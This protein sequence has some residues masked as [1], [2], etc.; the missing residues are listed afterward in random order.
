MH[1][2]PAAEWI[3]RICQRQQDLIGARGTACL[4]V[5]LFVFSTGF[6]HSYH[7]C[8]GLPSI[9]LLVLLY[10]YTS[11]TQL[12]FMPL[13]VR[14]PVTWVGGGGQNKELAMAV[15]KYVTRSQILGSKMVV[16]YTTIC[17]LIVRFYVASNIVQISSWVLHSLYVKWTEK[18]VADEMCSMPSIPAGVLSQ[19]K[20]I[21]LVTT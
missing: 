6:F 10:A 9:Y 15:A 20:D 12:F 19:R 13:W 16:M 14:V 2:I 4:S 18:S 7:I 11:W 1:E 5:C 8:Q 17:L 21:M 3:S